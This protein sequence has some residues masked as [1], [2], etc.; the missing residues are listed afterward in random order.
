MTFY[1]AEVAGVSIAEESVG[2]ILFSCRRDKYLRLL[3]LPCA[4]VYCQWLGDESVMIHRLPNLHLHQE[5]GRLGKRRTGIHG[6]GY[7]EI[8]T[9]IP[10]K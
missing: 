4:F 2:Y 9:Q 5:I 6:F 7:A 10:S 8:R 1:R 3:Y